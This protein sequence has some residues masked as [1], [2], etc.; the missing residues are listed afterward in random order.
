M[1]KPSKEQ[2]AVWD[3]TYAKKN[4]ELSTPKKR[5]TFPNRIDS[6]EVKEAKEVQ[7]KN[8]IAFDKSYF[9]KRLLK[10]NLNKNGK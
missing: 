4:K 8:K 9:G 7:S 1:K 5:N 2:R 6:K 3:A 10:I